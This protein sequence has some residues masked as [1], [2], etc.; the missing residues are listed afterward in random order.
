MIVLTL[1]FPR[2]PS[3]PQFSD[4]PSCSP[5]LPSMIF[6]ITTVIISNYQAALGSCAVRWE[7]LSPH[8]LLHF[9]LSNFRSRAFLFSSSH[10]PLSF[11]LLWAPFSDVPF[12]SFYI[13]SSIAFLLFF[14]LFIKFITLIF[15]GVHRKACLM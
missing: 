7:F 6:L 10:A 15:L 5:T 14:F 11:L 2:L 9:L 8:C 1:S 4:N 12:I 3:L 13:Y